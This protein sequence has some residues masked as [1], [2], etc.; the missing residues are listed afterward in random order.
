MVQFQWL[1]NLRRFAGLTGHGISR[2][3]SRRRNGRQPMLE[4]LEDRHLLSFLPPSFYSVN[5]DPGGLA[6]GD[7]NG[8]GIPDLVTTN[9]VS[10]TVL[11]G[12]V[13]VLLGNGD[14]T[15]QAPI[16][17]GVGLTPFSV[18]LRDFNGD[19]ILDIVTANDGAIQSEG[20]DVSVLLGNG[21]G[22]FQPA[23]SYKAGIAPLGVDTADV[24]GDGIPDIVA[25]GGNSVSV[26]LGNGDGTFQAPILSNVGGG[27]WNLAAI[28]VN[29]DGIPDVVTA[30]GYSGDNVSVLL[31]NGD[32]TF[33][34]PVTYPVGNQPHW[35]GVCDCNGD[36]NVDVIT[37][38]YGSDTVSILLGNGDGTFK[39]A[40]NYAAGITPESIDV[41]D[42]NGDGVPDIVVPNQ[43]N[44]SVSVLLGN[45]DGTYQA[46]LTYAAGD[47]PEAAVAVDVNGDG[48]P[49]V[50]SANYW[51][52]N[53]AVLLNANDWSNPASLAP[54]NHGRAAPSG[55][56]GFI[57]VV[58]NSSD[59]LRSLS[60]SV[61][62]LPPEAL[63]VTPRALQADCFYAGPP[64][65]ER[66]P[67]T[68]RLH[69]FLVAH[70]D[71]L[72]DMPLLLA[73]EF[74]VLTSLEG[75]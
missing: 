31:G 44:Q 14:G 3:T 69:S 23:V 17:Y 8:D 47:T 55:K 64:G 19:G 66:E 20:H 63:A 22:T 24:N 73:P 12:T 70:G 39:P 11:P 40:V 38:N 16:Q 51:G 29:G 34:A 18:A 71:V 52:R 6:S 37:A 33:Q 75:T 15:F 65:T 26:L 4:P 9:Y 60:D 48:L 54:G 67:A 43:L 41:A 56:A 21:D 30:N 59:M 1:R 58:P 5:A 13:S 25:A 50:V 7:L 61:E 62:N 45:G 49:D 2:T 42:F 74:Q 27:A 68:A 10:H 28:D 57:V 72:P 32:G 53:V 36:G 35:V 46:P